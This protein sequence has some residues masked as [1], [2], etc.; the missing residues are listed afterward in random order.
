[1]KVQLENS[2]RK[3]K[4]YPPAHNFEL[5]LL[6]HKERNSKNLVMKI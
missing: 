1:M 3:F 6:I 4:G 5:D 2:M